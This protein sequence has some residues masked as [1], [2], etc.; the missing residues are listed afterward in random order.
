MLGTAK[1]LP[2]V[3][4]V[5]PGTLGAVWRGLP[6][7]PERVD[8][9]ERSPLRTVSVGPFTLVR[10]LTALVCKRLHCPCVCQ[11][12][13]PTNGGDAVCA[14]WARQA[15]QLT[16]S[17]RGVGRADHPPV[18]C[19]E[20]S[21]STSACL[22]PL[23]TTRR[24]WTVVFKGWRIYTCE[25]SARTGVRVAD[26]EVQLRILPSVGGCSAGRF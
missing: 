17:S 14:A 19:W 21:P 23:C 25:L 9:S 10:G 8:G 22:M 20:D 7:P 18:S 24:C 2:V 11:R 16:L 26:G 1:Y 6:R 5:T 13:Q 4:G 3:T 12:E 15:T